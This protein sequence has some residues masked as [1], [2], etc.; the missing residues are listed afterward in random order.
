MNE[1]DSFLKQLLGDY[2]KGT[3]PFNGK[4]SYKTF[5]SKPMFSNP[6]IDIVIISPFIFEVF[7]NGYVK[8]HENCFY[9]L[10]YD[11]E[12]DIIIGEVLRV[13]R[14]WDWKKQISFFAYTVEHKLLESECPLCNFWLVQR[15]NRFGHDFLG[16]SGFPECDFSKEIEL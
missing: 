5:Y 16:C 15:T 12:T 6:T 9:C 1:I 2:K 13:Y 11:N 4:Y 10:L 3:L 14:E 8:N 7:L